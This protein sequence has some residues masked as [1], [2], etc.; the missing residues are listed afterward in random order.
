MIYNQTSTA[1]SLE[2]AIAAKTFCTQAAFEVTSEALQVFGGNGLNKEYGIEK[3]FCDARASLIED[4]TTDVLS[5]AG[6]RHI[7][8]RNGVTAHAGAR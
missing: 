1:P 5:L 3:F 2:H 8:S 6:A 7:L 4:G